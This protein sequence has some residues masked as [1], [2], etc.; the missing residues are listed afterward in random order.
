[1]TNFDNDD[2]HGYCEYC[3]GGIVEEYRFETEPNIYS[4]FCSEECIED[5]EVQ[6]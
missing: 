5:Y 3:G 4:V 1:M 6:R 2:F